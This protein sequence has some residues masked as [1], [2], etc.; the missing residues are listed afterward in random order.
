MK[1]LE[2]YPHNQDALDAAYKLWSTGE[3]FAAIVHAVG[4]GKSFIYHRFAQDHID[5][6]TLVCSPSNHIFIVQH[7]AV[8]RVCPDYD[9]DNAYETIT[10][11]MLY[12]M[13]KAG[14]LEPDQYDNIILDEFHRCGAPKWGQ[15]VKALL[16]LNPNARVLGLSATPERGDGTNMADALFKGNVV[17][18]LSLPEAM[19]REIL[20]TPMYFIGKIE[21]AEYKELRKFEEKA[22]EINEPERRD[23]IDQM[24]EKYRRSI[25]TSAEDEDLSKLFKKNIKKKNAKFI[26]FCSNRADLRLAERNSQKWFG[27]INHDIHTYHIY[28]GNKANE[29]DW[30]TGSNVEQLKAFTDDDSSAFKLLYCINMANE[31]IHVEGL[32]GAIMIRPTSSH[33]VYYQQVG[34]PLSAGGC[35]EPLIFDLVRNVESTNAC[36]EFFNEYQAACKRL[37]KPVSSKSEFFHFNARLLTK[38]ELHDALQKELFRSQTRTMAERIANVLADLER[39]KFGA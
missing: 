36:Y 11:I 27:G 15:G 19:A 14:L 28:A 20:P 4:T 35:K 39:K 6:R 22:D 33:G 9:F 24:I 8:Q 17:S 2:L 37:G 10:Y 23:K 18:E 30:Y 26:V 38:K 34:R 1:K 25:V 29:E 3:R 21:A 16:E 12:N 32:D 7:D 13:A 5:E 31:G